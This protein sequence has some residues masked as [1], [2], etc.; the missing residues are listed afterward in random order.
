VKKNCKAELE[1][2]GRDKLKIPKLPLR[3][4]TYTEVI[5]LLQKAGEDIKWGDD[6]TKPQEKKMTELVGEIAFVLKDWPAEIKPFYAM[7]ND[8]NPKVCRAFDLMYEGIEI[9]S[10]TQRVHLPE[11]LIKQLKIKELNPEDFKFYIDF[12]RY[13]APPHGGWSIGLERLT[14]QITGKKNIREATMFPRDRDRITP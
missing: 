4:V 2:L 3:R 12:F 7:P 10:G 8:K 1:L 9:C 5:E 6:F 13:G 14:M 11:L